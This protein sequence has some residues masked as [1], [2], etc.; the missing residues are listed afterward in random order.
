M[1]MSAAK[2]QAAKPKKLLTLE[3]F[4]GLKMK[5]KKTKY[6]TAQTRTRDA[7]KNSSNSLTGFNSR[8]IF[9]PS[10]RLKGRFVLIYFHS[11]KWLAGFGSG[12]R[13]FLFLISAIVD[14]CS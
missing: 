12:S 9:S 11:K 8:S 13:P 10:W 1:M 6:I 5:K 3:Y 14:F 2:P 4:S 7:R